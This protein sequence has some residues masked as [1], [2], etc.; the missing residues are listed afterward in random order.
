MR[1]MIVLNH[2]IINPT[3]GRGGEYWTHCYLFRVATVLSNA[4]LYFSREI[5]PQIDTEPIKLD[6]QLQNGG[7]LQKTCIQTQEKTQDI[8]RCLSTSTAI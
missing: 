6:D 8:L 7:C 4:I 2:N 3:R 5:L 1:D